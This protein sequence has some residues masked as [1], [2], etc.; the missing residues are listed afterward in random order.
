MIKKKKTFI[1][2]ICVVIM[3]LMCGVGLL[4]LSSEANVVS[5]SG[6]SPI[7]TLAGY[8]LHSHEVTQSIVGSATNYTESKYKNTGIQ[9]YASSNSGYTSTGTNVRLDS[10]SFYV[11]FSG[12]NA[13]YVPSTVYETFCYTTHYRFEITTSSG[14]TYWYIDYSVDIDSEPY[15]RVFNV[16]G[17]KTT[18]IDSEGTDTLN[19]QPTELGKRLVSLYNNSFNWTLTRE[20]TWIRYDTVNSIYGVYEST[21]TLSGTLLVDSATPVLTAKGY[22]SGS[23][24][25]SGSYV[26]ERVTFTVSDTNFSR[27]YYK[28]PGNSYYSSSTSTTYTSSAITGWWYVYAIDT[29]GNKTSEFSFYYDATKPIGTISSNGSTVS[30]GSYVSKSFSYTATDAHS[31]ISKLYYKSPVNSSYQ[32]YTSGTIIPATAGDGWYY[33]YAVDNAENTSSVSSVY[34]ETSTPLVEI[35]RNGEVAYSTTITGSGTFDTGIY[36]NQYDAMKITY[37]SSSDSVTC[38][39]ALNSTVY[40]SS[41]YTNSTYTITM[42]TPT[43]Y[44][45]N[46]LFHIVDTKPY[47]QIDGTKY[48]S[49]STLYFSENTYVSWFDDSDI[50]DS[51]DTGVAITTEGN[52]IVD[53]FAKYTDLSGLTLATDEGTDTIYHLTLND[54]AGNNSTY[55]III[56]KSPVEA[57]WVSGSEEIDNG[58]YSNEAVYLSYDVTEVASALYSKDGSEYVTYS[59][60]NL[61]SEDGVYT[62]VLT[63][64]A[65]N[66]S[67]YVINIDTVAPTGQLY[68]DYQAV[69]NNCVTNGKIYFT[70][71]GDNTATVNGNLYTKNT[72]ISSDGVYNFVLTDLAGNSTTYIIEIDTIAPEFNKERLDASKD[73]LIS[74]WYVVTTDDVQKSFADYESALEYA[75]QLEFNK[76]VTTLILDDVTNFTQYH[77]VASRGNAE[78]D[79]KAGTYYRYKSQANPNN[80]LY[81][82]NE[83]LLQEVIAFYA[84]EYVSDVNYYNLN[85]NT[86]GELDDSM[87]DNIWLSNDGIT[88]PL[89]NNFSFTE[90]DSCLVYMELVG[91][92][93]GKVPVEFNVSLKE[94]FNVTGLYEVTEMDEAGNCS[95]YYLFLDFTAPN[96]VVN[97]EVFGDNQTREITITSDSVSSISTYYYKS[98]A[99]TSIVDNDS[100]AT[101][102]ITND[103]VTTYY[104]KGDTLPVLTEGGKYEFVVYDR[105]NNSYEF[106]VYIVGNEATIEFSPNSE[107]TEFTIDISLEQEFDTI[108]S[109]EI[110]KDGE[111]LDGVTTDTL[112][113]T[114]TKDGTYTV[115]LRDN[116][117]RVIERTYDFDKSLPNGSL[118]IDNGSRTTE[119]VS[120]TFDNS[121]YVAEVTLDGEVLTINTTGEVKVSDDGNYVIKLIN[122]TD[123]DNFN[124]YEFTIDTKAPVVNLDGVEQGKTNNTDVSVSWSDEDVVSATYT[125]NNGEEINLVNGDV[126]SLEGT[127]EVKVI[128]D[129]GNETVVTFTIDKSLYYE[130]YVNDTSTTGVETT[131]EDVLLINNEEL[132][133]SV[134][135][136][137]ESYEYNFGDVLSEEGTYLI[138]ISDDYGN[139]TTIQI[140]IDKSV[141]AYLTTGN[142]S[143]SNEDV[144]ITA[145][146]KVSVIVTKDGK[147]YEYTLGQPITEEGK[148]KV[149]IY[150]AY[151]NQKT[152][153]FEIVKGTKTVL[154]YTLGENVEIIE[155]RH[156]GEVIE[157]DSNHLNFTTDGTYEVTVLVDG[158]EYSFELSLDTTAPEVTL[159]GIEDGEAG[160]VTVTITDMTEEGTIK[161][162]KDG[163]LI[164]YNLGDELKDYGNYVVEVTDELGNTRTYS[165]TLEYQMNGWA[166]ALIIIG[167]LTIL[168]IGVLIYLKRKGTFKD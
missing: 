165:F 53:T 32:T 116:F 12:A 18:K 142:G 83:S 27:L 80:E 49:G 119:E 63:D 115:I 108:V 4:T 144:V 103:G 36:F 70:W 74:K 128:D 31:G 92:A 3:T 105:L 104:S 93:E 166:I 141:D 163:E 85:N 45:C 30:S 47:I 15:Q 152:F 106:V 65:G 66:K 145:G 87:F 127:Y 51:G 39:F 168:G 68:A 94:Q 96:L 50:T 109:L 88:A 40:L 81:Y 122:L 22:T 20:Y 126:L 101:I 7:N 112:S 102:A 110:Y 138:K 64:K 123:E 114:F 164:D 34:L 73:Y 26:N 46:Y 139:T 29:V 84:K 130:V 78:D 97:A 159:N 167:I 38:N 6:N 124:T 98:F 131:G 162:Y 69:S 158:Q 16:N 58:G 23:T 137:G 42:T 149:T 121:K 52:K 118:S 60:E 107:A 43:G 77:L 113:Y 156:N 132:N 19:F 56:D 157:W 61:F 148:Y 147:P 25:S 9:I 54:R 140:T 48:S 2:S 1:K 135:R 160:N 111:K 125:L 62:I 150:D 99:V 17:S 151:G 44:T 35:Y 24:I 134:T 8:E 28:I 153:S 133:I 11:D 89:G 120:F 14:Y 41:A 155:V 67:T 143:I 13:M 33:F 154:D 86:Y 90:F 129:L 59:K 161:V 146:E 55:T 95:T 21:S 75:S 76:Y 91:G 57:V 71:D 117:G 37:D 79:V 82:F 72:V 10:T 136:N 5:A 100:W